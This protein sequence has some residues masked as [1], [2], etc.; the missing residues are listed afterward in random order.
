M[1]D[2][3][4][5]THVGNGRWR[6]AGYAHSVPSLRL[7]A[8]A[9][10]VAGTGSDQVD[11]VTLAEVLDGAAARYGAEFGE[12]LAHCTIWV[13]GDR[14]ELTAPVGRDD[15]VAILPPVSGGSC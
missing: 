7:F 13:N 14:S 5:A 6:G 15:E 3:E 1:P 11:G 9:R 10:E 4:N 8:Q 2:E 12:L